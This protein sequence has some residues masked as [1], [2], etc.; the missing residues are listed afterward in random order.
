MLAL[1]LVAEAKIAEAIRN[2]E[3]ADLPGAGKPLVLDDDRLVPEDV[4][5][6]YRILK[7]AGM[8]PPEVEERRDAANLRQLLAVAVD[9]GERRSIC[10]RLALL[11]ARLE[12]RGRALAQSYRD[13]IAAKFAGD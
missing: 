4:R 13:R 9:D 1:D 5:M 11:E 8:V 6:V 12:A 10:G 2:G 7:N 3:F